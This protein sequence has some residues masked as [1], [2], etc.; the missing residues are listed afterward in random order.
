MS[1]R[2]FNEN[3]LFSRLKEERRKIENLI[4]K[5]PEK[6]SS[7]IIGIKLPM[8]DV[9]AVNKSQ[10][11]IKNEIKQKQEQDR[12][13]QIR[14]QRIIESRIKQQLYEEQKK[15]EQLRQQQIL[16]EKERLRIEE[17]KIRLEQLKRKQ[18]EQRRQRLSKIERSIIKSEKSLHTIPSFNENLDNLEINDNITEL[19][20]GS[21]FNKPLDKFTFPSELE[22]LIL[23]VDFN[24][25]L[26]KVKF[27]PKLKILVFSDAFNHPLD[28]VKFPDSLRIVKFPKHALFNHPIYKSEDILDDAFMINNHVI[29]ISP[30]SNGKICVFP[31]SLEQLYLGWMF[32]HSL[33]DVK[34]PKSLL[35]LQL[36]SNYNLPLNKIK[37]SPN[38]QI[39]VLGYSYNHSL[40]DVNFPSTFRTLFINSK[41]NHK[42]TIK[43]NDKSK[44]ILP[45]NITHLYLEMENY[46]HIIDAFPSKLLYLQ[47]KH[48]K[49]PLENLPEGI[50]KIVLDL[51]DNIDVY[52]KTKFPPKC[53]VEINMYTHIKYQ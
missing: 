29:T 6:D 9:K 51:P 20:F 30:I 17:E 15:V 23:G 13:I 47:I 10:E 33:D 28:N 16:L 34:L 27:P 18:E 2:Y 8:I 11:Q 43:E 25:P 1:D 37:F 3:D 21:C 7:N 22:I 42:L 38:F 12:L 45:D 46:N 4:I 5:Q 49:N 24:H 36:S 26:D 19:K 41:F 14:K 31:D 39:L 44:S 40:E 50:K 53:N 35:K 48:L 32:K 52:E